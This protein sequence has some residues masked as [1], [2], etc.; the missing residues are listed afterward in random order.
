MARPE[1][2]TPKG[3]SFVAKPISEHAESVLRSLPMP[4]QEINPGVR[5]RLL[6]AGYVEI[7]R[8]PSPYKKHKGL[9]IDHYTRSVKGLAYLE[10]GI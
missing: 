10:S 4:A 6:R 3:S 8:L 9:K 1:S 2:R 5:D 7:V